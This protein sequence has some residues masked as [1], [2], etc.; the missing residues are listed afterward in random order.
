MAKATAP[1]PPPP[2][3]PPAP[4]AAGDWDM[5]LPIPAGGVFGARSTDAPGEAWNLASMPVGASKLV[6]DN[7]TVVP[8]SVTDAAERDAIF[9]EAQ[10]K[11][12]NRVTG[13]L[14]RFR[15]QTIDGKK[16][17]EKHEHTVRK[18]GDEK[19]GYGIRIWRIK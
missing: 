4:P 10:K 3:A 18:V 1:T 2:P 16:P 6:L 8:D 12:Y 15:E 9:T 19:L 5:D 17:Y 14:R 13:T 7:A 11:G